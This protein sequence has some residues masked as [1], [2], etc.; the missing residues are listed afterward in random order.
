VLDTPEEFWELQHTYST[1]ARKRLATA[2]PELAR[3]VR[4]ELLARAAEVRERGGR[5]VYRY[6]ALFVV[7]D[8]PAK[9]DA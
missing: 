3:S 1:R 2:A 4:E 8:Q 7:A 6:A 9:G 5:L